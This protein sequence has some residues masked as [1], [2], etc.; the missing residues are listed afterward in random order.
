MSDLKFKINIETAAGRYYSYFTG[1]FAKTT[2]DGTT[3]SAVSSSTILTRI[4]ELKSGSYSDDVTINS[5]HSSAHEFDNASN[6]FLSASHDLNHIYTGSIVIHHTDSLDSSDRL[7]RYK[8][9]GTKVCNAL[10]FAEGQWIYPSNFQL[11]DTGGGDNYFAGDVSAENLTVKETIS[12]SNLSKITSDLSFQTEPYGSSD[13]FI[14]FRSGSGTGFTNKAVIGY[15]NAGDTYKIAGITEFSGSAKDATAASIYFHD[16]INAEAGIYADDWISAPWI[17]NAE[18][19]KSPEND[20]IITP[21]TT[22][23]QGDDEST[24]GHVTVQGQSFEVGSG[25]DVRILAGDNTHGATPGEDLYGGNVIIRAGRTKTVMD[26]GGGPALISGSIQITGSFSGNLVPFVSAAYDLGSA[27]YRWNNIYTTDLQ[28][29][30]VEKEN[31][32]VVD[33]TKGNWTLQEGEEDL[34][35]INNISGK[36]YKIAL[37]P[38]DD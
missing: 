21:T 29:S 24:G 32:N 14:T 27:T 3:A 31:G 11:D 35:A 5:F 6:V 7:K 20:I 30:N 13:Q 28:L 16:V 4:N 17:R 25:G 15:D 19:S 34:F 12:F 33:G 8:F 36:K 22:V 1:S 37:I 26:I 10:G 38:Q 23:A 18:G 9:W 2:E